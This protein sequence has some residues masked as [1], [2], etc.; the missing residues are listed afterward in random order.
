MGKNIF[1]L[2]S[3]TWH[4]QV[5]FDSA[6]NK[7]IEAI[8]KIKRKKD[9]SENDDVLIFFGGIFQY[10]FNFAVFAFFIYRNNSQMA[11]TKD[12]YQNLV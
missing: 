9:L 11:L 5:V 8:K 3:S 1:L 7:V 10:L 6:Q 4:N 12:V 2:S